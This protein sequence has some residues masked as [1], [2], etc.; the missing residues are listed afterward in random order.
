MSAVL[1]E[2]GPDKGAIWHFGEPNKEQKELV[3]GNGWA[4]LSHRAVISISGKDRLNWLHALTTQHLEKLPVGLW[5]DALILDTQGHIVEQLFLVDDGEITWIHTE[6]ER[7]A[8]LIEY[9]EKMKFMLEVEVKDQSSNYAVL[10]AAGLADKIGGPYALVPRSELEDT[11]AAFNKSHTQVGIW[12]LE[13]LR[14]A[15]GRA[16]LLFEVDHKSI[17]NEL[18]FIN[19]AVHMKKGCYRGQETVAKVFNL[20]QPPRKL[21]LLHL[22][23]S[24]VGMPENGA[25]L[26]HNEKE[27]GYIGTLARHYELGP[28]ALAVIKRNTPSDAVLIADGVAAN[29]FEDMTAKS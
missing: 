17:P 25:K 28:I 11:K 20:G 22:D 23:G 6:A 4:D 3:A 9:L 12:A 14:V 24:L 5:V 29:I 10:R 26:F 2:A 21:V 7:V 16:R 8:P 18:G 13:A 1:V 27:V 19:N 15:Q